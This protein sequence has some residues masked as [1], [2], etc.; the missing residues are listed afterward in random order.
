MC[1]SAARGL[2]QCAFPKRMRRLCTALAVIPHVAD[3]HAGMWNWSS[4]RVRRACRKPGRVAPGC[5]ALPCSLAVRGRHKKGRG[6]PLGKAHPSRS[7]RDARPPDRA[8]RVS[9]R[10]VPPT[11]WRSVQDDAQAR[12]TA[13][14]TPPGIHIDG[15]SSIA[16]RSQGDAVG[17]AEPRR[18]RSGPP[19]S[20]PHTSTSSAHAPTTCH[21][22]HAQTLRD[23]A[24]RTP[25]VH[26]VGFQP[27]GVVLT[28][29]D[30]RGCTTQ[31]QAGFDLVFDTVR[32]RGGCRGIHPSSDRRIRSRLSCRSHH[33]PG[34]APRR[35][36]RRTDR[37]RPS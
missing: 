7:P 22:A 16:G 37:E 6:G 3:A 8:P 21:R 32:R 18:V 9:A 1:C 17:N 5:R 25:T 15:E 19:N 35:P 13:M 20:I 26:S 4:L 10:R 12:T 2:G 24:E 30:A 27:P 31:R 33:P 11:R 29:A 23:A 28:T 34:R 14:R 36:C